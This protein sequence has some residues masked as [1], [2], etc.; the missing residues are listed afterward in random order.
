MF[1]CACRDRAVTGVQQG[2]LLIKWGCSYFLK[3]WDMTNSGIFLIIGRS[4]GRSV[5]DPDDWLERDFP[6]ANNHWKVRSLKNCH[7]PGKCWRLEQNNIIPIKFQKPLDLF[8]FI[9]GLHT[10]WSN[11]QPSRWNEN[12]CRHWILGRGGEDDGKEERSGEGRSRKKRD[13]MSSSDRC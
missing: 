5:S 6:G 8:C 7:F 13:S 10:S 2:L 12:R 4:S 11:S 9:L 3:N 1:N